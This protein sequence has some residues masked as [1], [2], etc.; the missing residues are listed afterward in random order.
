[1]SHRSIESFK[2]LAINMNKIFVLPIYTRFDYALKTRDRFEDVNYKDEK[3]TQV[4]ILGSFS[5]RRFE[6]LN[7]LTSS[8]KYMVGALSNPNKLFFSR[9]RDLYLL[10]TSKVSILSIC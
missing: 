4:A 10:M 8:S 9:E 6:I 1:M 5:S 2:D 3:Q 7:E